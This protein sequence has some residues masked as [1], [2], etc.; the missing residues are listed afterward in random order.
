MKLLFI[1]RSVGQQIIDCVRNN[2]SFSHVELYDF[3]ANNNISTDSKCSKA[4]NSA[5]SALNGDTSPSGFAR[6]FRKA[7]TEKSIRESL[8]EF[9]VIGFKSCYSTNNIQSLNS[10]LNQDTPSR[11]N[12]FSFATCNELL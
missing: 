9:D 8:M 11:I 10:P 6:F 7:M 5:L 4:K 12:P 1:H 2:Q 3:N